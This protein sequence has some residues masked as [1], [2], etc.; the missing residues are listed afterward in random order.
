MLSL[1]RIPRKSETQANP[2]DDTRMRGLI[3]ALMTEL[4]ERAKYLHQLC[5]DA[6]RVDIH[7][8]I[9]VSDDGV[10][11]C[12]FQY[13]VAVMVNDDKNEF[14][15]RVGNDW[16]AA[17]LKVIQ[18]AQAS[19]AFE[20]FKQDVGYVPTQAEAAFD[21]MNENPTKAI[22]DL[23]EGLDLSKPDRFEQL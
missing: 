2:F 8:N 1:S 3:D 19:L 18:D 11:R 14:E 23:I 13:T 17:G 4:A 16:H 9:D 15:I 5:P 22:D 12:S 10:N 20:R 21:R 7:P 6:I